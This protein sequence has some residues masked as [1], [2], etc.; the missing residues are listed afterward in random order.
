M[1]LIALS[2]A[3]TIDYVSDKDPCKVPRQVPVDPSDPK[4]GNRTEYDIEPGATVFKLAALD[5][6][7]MGMIYDNASTIS[8]KQGSDEVGINTRMNQTNIDAVRHGLV[9][10]VNFS[11]KKGNAILFE[12]QKA[13]IAGREYQVVADK[14]M[15]TLGIQLIAELAEKIKSISEV[16][17]AEEKNSA[18]A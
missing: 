6:F 18:S 3:D 2:V 15:N 4:K 16:T 9:G 14:V 5:V 17:V 13:V 12:T 8:G 1:A 7:L 10:F 11:D